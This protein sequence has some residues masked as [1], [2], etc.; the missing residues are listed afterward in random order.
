MIELDQW[1]EIRHLSKIEQVSQREI[2]RRLGVSRK[3]VRKA[4]ASDEVPTY[5]RV[6]AGSKIDSLEPSMRALLREHPTLRAT[7]VAE[8]VGYDCVTSS[9][10]R[11]RVAQIKQEL[12][13]LDPADRLVFRP[14]EQ[15]QCDLWFPKSVI[16]ETGSKQ[17]VLTMVACWSRFLQ[18]LML[19]SRQCGDILAGM[20]VLLAQFAGLPHRLLWDNESGIVHNR[21]LIPQASAWAGSMGAAI[22]LAKPADPETKGRIERANRYLGESFE[23]ARRFE[24]IA[25]FNQQL[26]DWLANTAN[27]RLVRA[28][29]AR[30]IDLLTEERAAMVALP[31]LPPARIEK[32]IRLPRSY[33]VRIDSCDYSVDPTAIGR[34]INVFADLNR[35]WATCDGREVANH[36]RCFKP[37]E[38]ITDANHAEEAQRLR[39]QFQTEMAIARNR[40]TPKLVLVENRNL[41]D[42]D[43]LYQLQAA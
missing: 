29:G 28:T 35:V 16:E 4:L 37:H 3:T 12:G 7:V 32:T 6:P 41:A 31:S 27:Q 14:G 2:A 25:D 26:S 19:P 36:T 10:F 21:H 42:Y 20:N 15:I 18:A 9:I 13:V 43:N 39:S 1:S 24:T 34:I 11:A 40:Q 22:R 23:P 5:H 33:Y 38:T 8:R 17:P 30:P